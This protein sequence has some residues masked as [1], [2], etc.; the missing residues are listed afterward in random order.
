MKRLTL[1]LIVFMLTIPCFGQDFFLDNL[2]KSKWTSEVIINDFNIGELK[3][4]GLSKL[5][6]PIDS[7]KQNV[8]I[9]N[10]KDNELTIA[11]YSLEKGVDSTIVK[12]SYL[13]D[14]DKKL[15]RINH[16]SQDSISWE[17]SMVMVSTGSYIL[18]TR[19]KEK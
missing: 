1:I 6:V 11:K 15:L 18:M 4:I 7:I 3:E 9:W 8:S 19:K 13:Y 2:T 16:W 5:K 12:C 17:Y 10:F 14:E